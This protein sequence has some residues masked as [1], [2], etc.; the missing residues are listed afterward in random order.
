[1]I[2]KNFILGNNNN[3]TEMILKKQ[4][5]IRN[6]VNILSDKIDSLQEELVELRR[7]NQGTRG[8]QRNFTHRF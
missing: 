6:S 7:V 3:D 5:E 8:Y 4:Y 2:P 1:M